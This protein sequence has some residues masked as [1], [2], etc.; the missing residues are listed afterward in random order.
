MSVTKRQ[1]LLEICESPGY[2]PAESSE[3][4][5]HMVALNAEGWIIS[6]LDGWEATAR[7]LDEYPQFFSQPDIADPGSIRV[8]SD[9]SGRRAPD[10][11]GT[12]GGAITPPSYTP[13]IAVSRL[14]L[15][16]M[17]QHTLPEIEEIVNT[18]RGSTTY[19]SSTQKDAATALVEK[20]L[21]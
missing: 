19:H 17:Q 16:L 13:E 5:R 18:A 2:I 15:V 4:D 12:A 9:A 1:L 21:A 6:R 20:L 11:V 14:M 10:L 7:A 3:I 8:I